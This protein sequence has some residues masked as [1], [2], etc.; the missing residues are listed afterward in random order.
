[1]VRVLI[2]SFIPRSPVMRLVGTTWLIVFLLT[3]PPPGRAAD[4]AFPGKS[5]T[6]ASP[7]K[8]GLQTASLNK[9]RDYALKG[10]GSG[11]VTRSG[12]L[13]LSWAT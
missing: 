3:S 11:F 5:W 9:A 6:Q 7:E 13:V 2:C 8:M 4:P 1:M 10:G 12:V